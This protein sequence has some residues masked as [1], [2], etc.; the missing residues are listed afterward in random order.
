MAFLPSS[1][2]GL[3]AWYDASDDATVTGVDPVTQWDDKS[4]NAKHLSHATLGPA[5]S[6][7]SDR[8]EFR[9]A[10]SSG[11]AETLDLPTITARTVFVFL[12]AIN[13]QTASNRYPSLLGESS[14]PSS[15]FPDVPPRR[16]GKSD[17]RWLG[18]GC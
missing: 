16:P 8:M 15:F 10:A 4:G 2:S 6:D 9:G 12:T 18:K 7:A 11:V 17:K 3:A 1:L 13:P 5:Y 14:N